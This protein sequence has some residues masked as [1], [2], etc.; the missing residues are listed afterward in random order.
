[1]INLKKIKKINEGLFNNDKESILY[2]SLYG[3]LSNNYS[4]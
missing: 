1:M 3:Y 2:N 4:F